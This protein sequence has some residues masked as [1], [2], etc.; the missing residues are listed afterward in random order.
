M[1]LQ[2]AI[3]AATVEDLAAIARIQGT[4]PE[5]SQWA[6]ASYLE[7]GCLVAENNGNV[8]GFLATRQTAPDEREVLNLAV[9]ASARRQGIARALLETAIKQGIGAVFLE[10]RASNSA[11]LALY[12]AAG[13]RVVGERKRYYHDPQE[14]GIVM[15]FDS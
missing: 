15:K 9:E 4:A 5:A 7:N 2:I 1:D 6:P 13:F 11:A 10:V 14:N 3:R 12:R 8:L